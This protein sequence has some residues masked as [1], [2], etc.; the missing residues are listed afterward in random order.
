VTATTSL[1]D[2]DDTPLLEEQVDSGLK[3]LLL[4]YQPNYQLG[5][6]NRD[7]I[8]KRFTIR[9][10]SPLTEYDSPFAKAYEA[11]DNTSPSRNLYALALG[12]HFSCRMHALEALVGFQ[13]PNLI[14]ILAASKVYLTPIKESR[15]VAI[16]EK[17][18]GKSLHDLILTQRIDHEHLIRD[19]VLGPLCKALTALRDKQVVHAC[20]NTNT[21]FMGETLQLGECVSQIP[22]FLQHYLYEPPERM[23]ST[24]IAKGAG[25]EKTDIYAMAVL[26]YELLYGLDHLKKV[27]KEQFIKQAL[28]VGIYNI[29]TNNID[30]PDG[31]QDFFRG[32]L[33][34]NPAERWG[35]DQLQQ[36]LNG[37]RFNMITVAAARETSRPILFDNEQFFSPRA[38]AS[39]M[40]SSWREAIKETRNMKLDRWA[41]MSLHKPEMGERLS[42][43]VR[44][45]GSEFQATD[46]QNNDMV[47]R[48]ICL[49]DPNGPLRTLS[50]SMMPEG[51]GYLFAEALH[52]NSNSDLQQILDLIE[53]D[54]GNFWQELTD[55][56]KQSDTSQFAWR[57]SRARNMMKLRSLGFGIERVLYDLNPNLPCRSQMVSA[58]HIT[59]LIDLLRTL[60]ALSKKLAPD[61]ALLDRHIAAFIASKLDIGK[62]VK[63]ADMS[64]ITPLAN[65]QE[66]VMM[67]IIAKAQQKADKIPLPG[68][69]T[70]A[71]MRIEM[72]L[73]SIHNR[74]FRRKLKLQLKGAARVGN[75]HDLIDLLLNRDILQRDYEGFSQA[76]ALH[77]INSTR[78]DRLRNPKVVEKMSGALGGRIAS[79]LSY[80]ILGVTFFSVLSDFMN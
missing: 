48:I 10:D 16:I 57:V 53:N 66:L 35:L 58:Y 31:M 60:D 1:L 33:N 32:I 62:E 26:A 50:M 65:N 41:E 43:I 22:G 67:R 46:R 2:P 21:I 13:H 52:N 47:T 5:G 79:L 20:I 69:C 34:D 24:P 75:M 27:S 23:I 61:T 72:M 54:I 14:P 6:L 12:N 11:V 15:E 68:L 49:L 42:R 29:F 71:A 55:V 74:G 70:W 39:A 76:I 19:V 78:I 80:V 7:E 38:L 25:T 37:K 28:H 9:I 77:Q 51:I 45:A 59:D 44:M 30:L 18:L 4:N 40:H 64:T 8:G 36:W 73:D 3:D 56:N 17:P 63:H